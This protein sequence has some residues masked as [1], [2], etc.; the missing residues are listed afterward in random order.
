MDQNAESGMLHTHTAVGGPAL[1][2][3][4]SLHS[5]HC[6]TES[7]GTLLLQLL[8]FKSLLLEAVEE[9]HIR[10]DAE[11]RFEDQISKLLLEKQELDREKDSLQRQTE[12]AVSQHEESLNSVKKEFQAKI[13]NTEEEKGKYQVSAE[14]KDKEINNLKEELKSLQFLKFNLEKKAGELE[15]KLSLQSRMKD[16]HLNQLGEVEKHFS[17]LSRKC[18]MVKQAHEKLEQN[19]DEAMKINN[20]LKTAN[21]KQEATIVSLKKELEEVCTKLIK[22]KMDSVRH[23]K[24]PGAT[25]RE[26]QIMQHLQH[27][28][29]LET[30]MTKKLWEEN[31]TVRSEKQEVLRSLQQTQQLLLSQAQTVSRVELQLQIQTEQYQ[32]L[33]QE[34]EVMREKSK[35]TE[36]KVA[37]LMES[38]AASR[39]SWDKERTA[40]LDRITSER[41]ALQ[42]ANET[43]ARLH[44]KH[45]QL[46]A[47]V[48]TQ[49]RNEQERKD[50]SESQSFSVSTQPFPTLSDKVRAE[51][52]NEP[53]SSSEPPGSSGLQHLASA[54]IK[55]PDSLEDTVTKPHVAGATGGQ[56][57]EYKHTPRSTSFTQVTCPTSINTSTNGSLEFPSE[58]KSHGSASGKEVVSQGR[59]RVNKDEE[60]RE[61]RGDDVKERGSAAD[62]RTEL[63]VQITDRAD[64]GKDSQRSVEDGGQGDTETEDRVKQEGTDEAEERGKTGEHKPES[65][66]QAQTTTDTMSEKSDTHQVI[67]MEDAESPVAASLSQKDEEKAADSSH[68]DNRYQVIREERVRSGEQQRV[69]HESYSAQEAHFSCHED[70]QVSAHSFCPGIFKKTHISNVPEAQLVEK[71]AGLTQPT[72]LTSDMNEP[73]ESPQSQETSRQEGGQLRSTEEPLPQS[74]LADAC[75]DIRTDAV[76]PETGSCQEH[77]KTENENTEDA[78]TTESRV[79]LRVNLS[80]EKEGA[81]CEEWM[82]SKYMLLD[83]VNES[84]SL[85]NVKSFKS[86]SDWSSSDRRTDRSSDPDGHLGHPASTKPMFL[87]SLH[88]KVPSVITRAS[89]LLNASSVSGTPGGR[90]QQ[91][92]SKAAA[93]DMET[94]ASPCVSSFTVSTSSITVSRPSWQSSK[95]TCSTAPTSVTKWSPEP[96]WEPC[97]SQ[98]REDQ[99][100]SF[101]AQI[102][103]IEQFLKTERL[104]LPKRPRTDD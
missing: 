49:L 20:Q 42:A 66:T 3:E 28:L 77:G 44:Q 39:T 11:T 84:S 81:A 70:F 98:E 8:E 7:G 38:Y 27:K 16:S 29:N 59:S 58:Q 56:P 86:T 19:V 9:L 47:E 99:Q 2:Q 52:L 17:A 92:E 34:H 33:K 104:R 71:A 103:K 69:S 55:K 80:R 46:Q 40:L 63:M 90:S 37:Q 32:A 5:T 10:R 4:P 82:P 97:C 24:N 91:G 35:E 94:E 96:D 85:P 26:Q 83:A 31:A 48:L 18:A 1:E 101:R 50:S 51:T 62:S 74:E 68:V 95:G 72:D 45:V 12:N 93:G 30:E 65:R 100:S 67:D 61:V 73:Q 15:Q 79:H 14:L 13:R 43:C 25:S 76:D 102:S 53:I 21:E 41:Q 57:A 60:E 78:K 54:H 64:R 23:N 87:K 22:A 75:S 6:Q 36:D 88:N 89:D